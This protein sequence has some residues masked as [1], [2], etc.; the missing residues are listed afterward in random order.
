[1]HEVAVTGTPAILV[2]WS[3]SA[4]DHQTANVRWLSDQGAAVLVREEEI[5]GLADVVMRLRDHRDELAALATQ[6]SQLG[7]LHRRGA[8]AELIESVARPG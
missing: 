7:A 4:E 3:G 8:L 1:V 5:G 6:A 2:P